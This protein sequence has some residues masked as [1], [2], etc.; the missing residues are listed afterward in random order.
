MEQPEDVESIFAVQVAAFKNTSEAE[1]VNALRGKDDCICSVVAESNG[2]IVG[3]CLFTKVTVKSSHGSFK[4]AALGPVAVLPEWQGE[5]IGT[6]LII[7][8]TNIVIEKGH[9]ILFVLGD[10]DYYNRF[11]YS[12]AREFGFSLPCEVPQGAFMVA[13]LSPNVLHGKSGVVHYAK[14]FIKLA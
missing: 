6:M 13:G 10:P 3:H 5:K 14:E 1:L 12:D 4:A 8:A 2:R 7:T 9:Q 11:G